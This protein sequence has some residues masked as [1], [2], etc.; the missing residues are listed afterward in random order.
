M[1]DGHK[2][3]VDTARQARNARAYAIGHPKPNGFHIR[4]IVWGRLLATYE[5]REHEQI[6]RAIVLV[7]VRPQ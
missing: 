4:R 2:L 5:R 6:R 1:T 7:E 3:R